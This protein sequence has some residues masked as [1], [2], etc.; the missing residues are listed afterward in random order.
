MAIINHLMKEEMIGF[1]QSQSEE[2]IFLAKFPS[3]INIFI[4]VF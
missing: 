4:Y 2:T 3:W 1:C